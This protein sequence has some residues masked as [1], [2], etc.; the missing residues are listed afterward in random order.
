MLPLAVCC[1]TLERLCL[2]LMAN[3]TA[4]MP[5]EP[6]SPSASRDALAPG[7]D[8]AQRRKS[9]KRGKP[10]TLRMKVGSTRLNPNP[11]GA[12]RQSLWQRSGAS[13]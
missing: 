13:L 10:M 9:L 12:P 2:R 3:K 1:W 8:S 4:P 5:E 7:P 11:A 6:A